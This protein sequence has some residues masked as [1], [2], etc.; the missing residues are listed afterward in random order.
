MINKKSYL[1]A[2]KTKTKKQVALKLVQGSGI[3]LEAA[4]SA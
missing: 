2:I 3:T 4:A 1:F